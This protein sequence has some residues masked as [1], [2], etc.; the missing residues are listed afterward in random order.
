M[1]HTGPNEEIIREYPERPTN[2]WE[3]SKEQV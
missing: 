3:D 1:R 2:E